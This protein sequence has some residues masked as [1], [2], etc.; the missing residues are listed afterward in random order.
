MWDEIVNLAIKNG[1][2]AVLFMGLFVFVIKDSAS[3]EKKYQQTIQ[4]LTEHLQ[5]IKEIKDDVDDI[6]DV[7]YKTKKQKATTSSSKK[8]VPCKKS[9]KNDDKKS[10][11]V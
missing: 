6:K 4:N 3:R 1:L 8:V 2:W 7:V 9:D 11:V 10:E 5:I